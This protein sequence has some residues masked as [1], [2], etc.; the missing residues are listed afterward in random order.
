MA[1]ASC[2]RV[3]TDAPWLPTPGWCAAP[4]L[5]A[6]RLAPMMC[7]T[8]PKIWPAC[9]LSSPKNITRTCLPT[10]G[11]SWWVCRHAT[12]M[13][14][15]MPASAM[16]CCTGSRR[17]LPTLPNAACSAMCAAWARAWTCPPSM[18]YSSCR[19]ATRRWMWCRVW[20]VDAQLQTRTGGREEIWIHHHSYCHSRQSDPEEALNDNERFKVVWEILNA[21]R[22]HDDN[23]N[24]EVNSIELN[25]N[26][27]SK[28]TVTPPRLQSLWRRRPRP[29][30]EDVPQYVSHAQVS[31]QLD[32][33]FGKWQECIYAKLVEKVG[34]RFYW[35]NW[36]REVGLIARKLIDRITSAV[37]RKADHKAEFDKYQ[38]ACRTTSTPAWM[39]PRP[40]RCWLSTSSP[41]PCSMPLFADY[42]F[43]ENNSVSSSMQRMIIAARCRRHRQG[44]RGAG[45]FLRQRRTN[46]GHIDNLAG[47]QTVIKNL[48]EKFF[49]GAFRSPPPSSALSTP[50]WSVSI[51]S[52]TVST[53][54]C[55][56]SSAAVSATRTCTSSTLCRHRHLRDPPLCRAD[57]FAPRTWSAN[58]CNE[59]HCNEIVLLAYYI[60]DVNIESVYHELMHPSITCL[61]TASALPILSRLPRTANPFSMNNGSDRTPPPC[62][63]SASSPIKVIIANPPL[64]H[65]TEICQR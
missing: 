51:S 36:A 31:R 55:G 61:T 19:P 24:A 39:P 26:K 57:W 62:S 18:P 8:A 7:P 3:T 52:F 15:W 33:R 4:W 21:L 27:A 60:A 6:R 30:G 25:R 22:S 37:E 12:L 5:S 9:C 63:S 45:P 16:S 20:G 59:I 34:D 32:I 64:L 50:L 17:S 56:R 46:V 41:V 43:V 47:K 29:V 54:C 11:S 49:K 53:M 23:F 2:W 58:I 28:V 1:W 40:L 35:E 14:P 48:Y 13:A 42:Q 44:H 38:S 10:V 65:R